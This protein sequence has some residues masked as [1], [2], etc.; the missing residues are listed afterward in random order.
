MSDQEEKDK[1]QLDYEYEPLQQDISLSR[2]HSSPS[3]PIDKEIEA[4]MG[5]GSD[6]DPESKQK[7]ACRLKAGI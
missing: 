5:D 6:D 2:L 4:R 7:P 3:S 1:T